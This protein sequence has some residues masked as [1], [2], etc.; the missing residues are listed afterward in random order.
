MPTWLVSP[1][2]RGVDWDGFAQWNRLDRGQS[3]GGPGGSAGV[4]AVGGRAL[5]K[6]PAGYARFNT[7]LTVPVSL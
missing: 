1:D 7:C 5:G 4:A 2:V 3:G 6:P